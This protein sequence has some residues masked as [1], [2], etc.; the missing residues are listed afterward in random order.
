MK[1]PAVP[2]A[3]HTPGDVA[4]IRIVT[5]IVLLAL[6]EGVA[7]SG[8]LYK[9]VV[10]SLLAV[11]QALLIFLGTGDS[12]RHLGVTAFEIVIGFG[13]GTIAGVA[14]GV[15]F[16]LWRLLGEVLDPWVHYLAPTPKI[17]FLPVLI[18]LFGVGIGSKIAM[19]TIGAFFPVVVATYAGMRLV[20]P[21]LLKVAKSFQA[22]TWQ[23]VKMI[24]AP[25]LVVPVIGAMRIGLGASIIGTLLA[26]IKMSRA[27]L[28]YLIVQDYSLLRIPEMYSLLI[29]V[30]VIALIAN[31]GMAYLGNWLGN[32]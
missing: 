8:L 30:M 19:G 14:L 7:R 16:G 11:M 4:K 5:A 18:L 9:D 3:I 22:S 28:G 20:Q 13:L 21:V 12:Y 29:V 24:Y 6:Y 26:E 15:S 31:A 1:R 32:N 25:S 23:V 2:A 27:G 17:I 10:P